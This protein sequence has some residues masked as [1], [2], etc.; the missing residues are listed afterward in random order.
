MNNLKKRV[1]EIVKNL[2]VLTDELSASEKEVKKILF[3]VSDNDEDDR[4]ISLLKEAKYHQ[5]VDNM[6]YVEV[7]RLLNILLELYN[8]AKLDGVDLELDDEVEA[9]IKTSR[10]NY[11]PVFVYEGN[12]TVFANEDL[13]AILRGRIDNNSENDMAIYTDILKSLRQKNEQE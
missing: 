6:K 5:V 1:H 8:I 3:E 10:L 13:S 4:G 7:E 9:M 2:N 12:K 11:Q